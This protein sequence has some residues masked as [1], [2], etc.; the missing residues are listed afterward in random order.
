MQKTPELAQPVLDRSTRKTVAQASRQGLHRFGDAGFR[1]LQTVRLVCDYDGKVARGEIIDIAPNGFE[2][3]DDYGGARSAHFAR[4]R[5]SH[6]SREM[7]S[8]M[9]K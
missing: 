9:S 8:P 3:R 4:A 2:A 1:A 6:R 5:G 7:C